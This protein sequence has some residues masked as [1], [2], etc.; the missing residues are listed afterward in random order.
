MRLRSRLCTAFALTPRL[1][2]RSEPP[3]PNSQSRSSVLIN[4]QRR[5]MSR[6]AP[7]LTQVTR[8]NIKARAQIDRV[9]KLLIVAA[10]AEFFTVLFQINSGL[11]HLRTRY[12]R[13]NPGPAP[14]SPGALASEVLPDA[15][16][17]VAICIAFV[18][19]R[20]RAEAAPDESDRS[21]VTP[22]AAE[23]R[24]RNA[25]LSLSSLQAMNSQ[26]TEMQRVPPQASSDLEGDRTAVAPPV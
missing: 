19:F 18:Y 6:S 21:T 10:A 17:M 8:S 3:S 14:T 9:L 13:S 16:Q 20:P 25:N 15:I 1:S 7:R 11:S 24:K 4:S 12:T 26:L 22:R 2:R 5:S 23:A